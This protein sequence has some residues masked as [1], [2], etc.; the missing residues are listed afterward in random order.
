MG[1]SEKATDEKWITLLIFLILLSCYAYFFPRWA[2]WNQNSRLNL[3]MATV[4]QGALYIDDYY[5]GYT[6]T[7]DYAEYE[8]HIYSTKATGSAFLGVPVYWAFQKVVGGGAARWALSLLRANEAIG[9][10]LTAGGSGLLPE[11]LHAAL[12]LSVVTFFTTSIPSALLGAAFLIGYRH[13]FVRLG[14][15]RHLSAVASLL[16]FFSGVVQTRWT[17]DAPALACF[18]WV[19]LAWLVPKRPLW[20][21]V[22]LAL[23]LAVWGLGLPYPPLSIPLAWVGL[24]LVVALRPA[25]LRPAP[26]LAALLASATAIGLL[27]LY[28]RDL[29]PVLAT[30]VYPGARTSTGGDIPWLLW[31]DQLLPGLAT[32]SQQ[33]LAAE[34]IC[35]GSS[36]GSWLLP[37][38]FLFVDHG[39]LAARLRR[40]PG[41]RRAA[42]ALAAAW[43]AL[44]A[45]MLLP[46]PGNW[47]TW[48]GFHRVPPVRCLFPAGVLL[49]AL[50]L[51]V[52]REA[53]LRWSPWRLA[54]AL[55]LAGA[56]WFTAHSVGARQGLT[57]GWLSLLPLVLPLLAL[58]HLQRH[59]R[60][61]LR[62]A[63]AGGALF[64]AFWAFGTFNPIQSSRPIF[65][66]LDT[67]TSRALDALQA[68][69]PR[70]WLVAPGFNGALLNG[71]GYRSLSHTLVQPQREFLAPFFPELAADEVERLFNRVGSLGFT[72]AATPHLYGHHVVDLPLRRFLSPEQGARVQQVP[73]LAHPLPQE[74]WIERVTYRHGVLA[75]E[76][77][78]RLDTRHGDRLT[79]VSDLPIQ[80]MGLLPLLRPDVAQALGRPEAIHSGF[81]LELVL[82]TPTPA[83]P[84]AIPLCLAATDG[85]G[86]TTVLRGGRWHPWECR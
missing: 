63:L 59:D 58:P 72:A 37:L 50:A 83:D 54:L 1:K 61:P 22:L 67:P 23:A 10:T 81:R 26:V 66:P 19:L 35:E 11:K 55:A 49:L 15:T 69:D 60:V 39:H 33:P 76:G 31:A 64:S 8:G 56:T 27:W 85:D 4:D 62:A 24:A 2:D 74:G 29:I 43:L 46:I 86:R 42:W 30:T 80:D 13:L 52:L 9:S 82:E 75:M 73:R 18:P 36:G 44:S 38:A 32:A 65:T 16:L 12:A 5:D 41:A 70:G 68:Q 3:V 40:S 28:Y 25:S 79:V 51:L 48:V 71:W 47:L 84:L 53:P 78:G 6:A 7:G 34:N 17:T 57:V 14:F 20:K 45:W 77:W 21:G